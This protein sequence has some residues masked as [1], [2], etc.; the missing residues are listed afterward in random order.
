MTDVVQTWLLYLRFRLVEGSLT[1]DGYEEASLGARRPPALFARRVPAEQRDVL[2]ASSPAAALPRRGPRPPRERP[3][4]EAGQAGSAG[5]G[6]RRAAGGSR[7]ALGGMPLIDPALVPD[8]VPVLGIQGAV[9]FPAGSLPLALLSD[10]A[11][12][13]VLAS[14]QTGGLVA[15]ALRRLP[16]RDD[17]PYHRVA[18]LAVVR[19]LLGTSQVRCRVQGLA[20]VELSEVR[21]HATHR[22]ARLRLLAEASGDAVA[23]R[24]R[25]ATAACATGSRGRPRRVPRPLPPGGAR[26]DPHPGPLAPGGSGAREPAR[27]PPTRS[28]VASASGTSRT[29]S[30]SRRRSSTAPSRTSPPGAGSWT[31]RSGDPARRVARMRGLG[32]LT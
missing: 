11:V 1:P 16:P 3:N 8:E 22:C 5:G 14:E 13:A 10:E 15:V 18:T 21:G 7:Y 9:L 19:D 23:R 27:S 2:D 26:A 6:E 20:R 17:E 32:A 12:A 4:G 28:S 25:R 31:R 30:R 29:G 24:R